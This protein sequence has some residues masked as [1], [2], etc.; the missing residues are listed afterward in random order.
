MKIGSKT[1]VNSGGKKSTGSAKTTR[2]GGGLFAAIFGVTGVEDVKENLRET[3]VPVEDLL[4][5]LSVLGRDLSFHRSPGALERYKKKVRQIIQLFIDDSQQTVNQLAETADGHHKQ[6]C[7]IKTIDENLAEL[8]RIAL[9][10]EKSNID[11]VA[12]ID[13]IRGILIDCLK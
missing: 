2:K 10:Q 8:T 1:T 13:N 7:L 9:D 12:Q 11:I 3:G 5:E 6:V 4:E